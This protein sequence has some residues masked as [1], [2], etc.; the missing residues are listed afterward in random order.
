MVTVGDLVV[1]CAGMDHWAPGLEN[2]EVVVAGDLGQNKH[3]MATHGPD[4]EVSAGTD[5]PV[6][7]LRSCTQVATP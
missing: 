6:W 7:Q 2:K 1:Y 3:A 4:G 5:R